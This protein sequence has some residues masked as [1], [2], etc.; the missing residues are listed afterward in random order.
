MKFGKKNSQNYRKFHRTSEKSQNFEKF[1]KLQKKK[2]LRTLG[3]FSEIQKKKLSEFQ[4]SSQ[5]IRISGKFS[6]LQNFLKVPGKSQNFKKISC[7]QENFKNFRKITL[8]IS[9]KFSELHKS[10]QNIR[11]ILITSEKF[12]EFQRSS[13]NFKKVLRTSKN[14][15]SKK[16]KK[17]ST[18]SL[19][20]GYI[21]I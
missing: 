19:V 14:R 5:N 12:S 6:Q 10:S 7:L 17:L 16:K 15:I 3:K 1:L 4:E 20:N 2:L 13:R 8:N 18:S 21:D 9:K 11:K